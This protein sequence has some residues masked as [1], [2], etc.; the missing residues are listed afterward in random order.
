MH[1]HRYDVMKALIE[2]RDMSMQ[3]L[4]MGDGLHMT[5]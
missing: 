2:S 1:F 3:D 4:V 5:L